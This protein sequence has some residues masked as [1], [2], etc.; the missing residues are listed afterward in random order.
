MI[1]SIS[2]T[3]TYSVEPWFNS[4]NPRLKI[5][6]IKLKPHDRGYAQGKKYFEYLYIPLF[7][8]G[9][10]I[11]FK[12]NINII[13]GSNGCGKSQLF[14]I[15]NNKINC[16]KD[17]F[18]FDKN[19]IVDF[20][21]KDTMGFDFESDSLKNII[22]PNS[23]D[24]NNFL[25]QTVIVLDSSEKSH[26]ENSKM[27]LDFYKDK[28]NN[29]LFMDEPENGLDLISQIEVIHTIKKLAT[30]NQI[31]IITHNK[32]IIESFDEIY[33]LDRHIWTTPSELFKKLKL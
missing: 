23:N 25:N 32:M 19:I 18:G 9:L 28:E 2:F 20:D 10:T 24:P 15:L 1:K 33:D 26:G 5:K 22:K 8:K 6:K 17:D 21:K 11:D 29:I 14:K 12:P 16:E 4:N 3:K 13:V 7:N 31:F 27:L 30:N